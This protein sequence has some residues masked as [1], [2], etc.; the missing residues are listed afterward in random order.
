M[1]AASMAGVLTGKV[2]FVPA[3]PTLSDDDLFVR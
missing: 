2:A 1:L 3:V